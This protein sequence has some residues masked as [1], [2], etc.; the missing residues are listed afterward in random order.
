MAATYTPQQIIDACDDAIYKL[1]VEG[2]AEYSWMGRSVTKR[3]LKEIRE[4]RAEYVSIQA[5]EDDTTGGTALAVFG[6]PV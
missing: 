5:A 1:V 6:D 4:V 2:I 3:N